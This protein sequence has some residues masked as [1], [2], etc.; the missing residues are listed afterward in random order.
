MELISADF[1]QMDCIQKEESVTLNNSKTDFRG[2]DILF[3]TDIYGK[4]LYIVNVYD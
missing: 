3:W 2:S 1:L 4:T